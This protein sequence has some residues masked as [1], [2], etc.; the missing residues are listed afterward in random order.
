M[1]AYYI[2]TGFVEIN[3]V[4]LTTYV[5][6]S[7][8]DLRRD[9]IDDTALSTS[10]TANSHSVLAGLQNNEMTFEFK[11]DFA[12]AKVDA[13]L[14]AIW[15]GSSAVPLVWRGTQA[16]IGATNPE[17]QMS[18]KLLDYS[19]ISGAVGDEALTTA[20]FTVTTIATRATSA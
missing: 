14:Y 8:V 10:A 5:K 11:Q 20:T 7:S 9:Q 2:V 15:N 17:Y 6:S 16:A 19:P 13:T 3:S 18:G 4:D 1:A 12:S